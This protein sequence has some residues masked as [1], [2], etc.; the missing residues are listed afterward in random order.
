MPLPTEYATFPRRESRSRFV[1]DRFAPYL[2]GSVLDVGCF[3]AP[4]RDILKDGSYTGVDIA[5][6]PDIELDLESV[7]R[8]PFDDG[9]FDTVICVEVLE[10]L[11]NLHAMFDELVRVASRD[12]IISLPNCWNTAR[13]RLEKGRGK[14]AHLGLP[15]ERPV[16]RHK[17]FFNTA[18][19]RDFVRAKADEQGV[20]IE[21]LFTTEKPRSAIL[22]GLRKLRYPGE[23]YQNLFTHTIWVR[24]RKPESGLSEAGRASSTP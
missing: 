21:E 20:V 2:R 8:L 14:I 1:A 9:S 16:N 4:L 17:W 22:R 18:E 5:G 15:V 10:H 11:D 3:E 7:E 19:A 12:I 23:R 13:R 24:L 6:R